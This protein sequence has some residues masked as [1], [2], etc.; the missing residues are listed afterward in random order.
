MS[1]ES[2]S[3]TF[4]NALP[5]DERQEAYETQI[6]PAPGRIYF[7]AA[8]GLGIGLNFA[9]PNRAPLLLTAGAEDRRIDTSLARTLKIVTRT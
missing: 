4:A 2:F 5:Y 6:V 8:L 3:E 1:F 9:N 7:Q